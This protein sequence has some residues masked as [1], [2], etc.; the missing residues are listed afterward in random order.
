MK[1]SIIE[2][3]LIT[4]LDE[5]I[6]ELVNFMFEKKEPKDYSSFTPSTYCKVDVVFDFDDS[7][8]P[9]PIHNQTRLQC[10]E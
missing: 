10:V 5:A 9:G 4:I 3:L 7:A 1:D 2:I 6:K 8:L